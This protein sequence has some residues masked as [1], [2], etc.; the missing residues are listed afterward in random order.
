MKVLFNIFFVLLWSV[1]CYSQNVG[2]N[3]SGA[4][5]DNSSMLD[6]VATDKGVLIPRVNI[7]DLNTAAPVTAPVTSLLVYN[8]NA[9][10]GVGYYF[11]DGAKWTKLEDANSNPDEDWHEVGGTT[12]PDNINDNIFTQGNVGIGQSNPQQ[13]LVVSEGN[14]TNASVAIEGFTSGYVGLPSILPPTGSHFGGVVHGGTNGQ[15]VLGIRDNDANDGVLIASGGGD[16]MSDN[17]YDNAVLFA[18]ND[19]NVGIGSVVPSSKLFIKQATDDAATA[20]LRI[21]NS[22]GTAGS[23]VTVTSDN[24]TYIGAQSTFD[25]PGANIDNGIYIANNTGNVGIGTHTPATQL[26]ITNGTNYG[27]IMLG[28]NG[29]TTNNHI[30]H[31]TSGDFVVWNGTFGSGN[32]LMSI[33]SNGR[34]ISHLTSQST[35]L[36]PSGWGGGI[37]SNWD[38][39]AAASVGG[40]VTGTAA[41]WSISNAG[42]AAKPGGG[43][44]AATS[45]RRTKKE[46]VEFTDGLNVLNQINPVTFMYNGL[47][48]TPND[49][50]KY[51]GIIA[52]DV[53]KVAPYM[54]GSYQAPKYEDSDHL[55]E[56]LNYDGGTYMLYVLVNSVK[57]LK[58]EN[59]LL[60]EKLEQLEQHLEH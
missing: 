14:A 47:Y 26:Q 20:A 46:I 34:I 3:T 37:E 32:R 9:A 38:V 52:Q 57:E 59:E 6:V 54:I 29:G 44:W 13:K 33:I 23:I 58:K 60:K 28:N 35:A 39:W 51:V 8:T 12:A 19:G 41:T 10:S 50:K 56:I 22:G 25:G 30:T 2:V 27:N 17:T 4:A 45:D 5:P 31:E 7:V 21:E 55:E 48:N 49:N 42:V 36:K 40:G 11:W 15:L 24:N 16:Y 53:K 43:A 18:R 1:N